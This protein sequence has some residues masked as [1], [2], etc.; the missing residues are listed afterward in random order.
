MTDDWSEEDLI[1]VVFEGSFARGCGAHCGGWT[2]RSLS[3]RMYD[4]LYPHND[5]FL[6]LL[7]NLNSKTLEV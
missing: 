6:N 1:C 2:D 7:V 3:V 5:D 4:G